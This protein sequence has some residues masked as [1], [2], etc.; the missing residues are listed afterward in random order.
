M[1]TLDPSTFFDN[2][3]RSEDG[4]WRAANEE[5]ISY[6]AGGHAS[7]FAVEDNS[8]WFQHRN[9]CIVEVVR[10]FAGD[11][12]PF[13]D[14]GG[15]NGVV[16]HALQCDGFETVLV[17]PGAEGAANARKRGVDHII[18]A[19][20]ESAGALPNRLPMVGLF[21]VIEHIEDSVAFLHRLRGYLHDDGV[22]FGTV[23]AYQWL[24]SDEDVHAGHFRRYTKESLAQELNGAG[25]RIEYVTYFFRPLIAPIWALRTLPSKWSPEPRAR[26]PEDAERDHASESG[27]LSGLLG[28]MLAGEVG[29]IR[30]GASLSFGASCL[31]AARVRD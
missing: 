28:R 26:A 16:A 27:R 21:D 14:V 22:L 12:R 30:R 3:T 2:L 5:R 31:F 19:T 1:S 20:L 8:F 23:P 25:L 7:C 9:R 18:Q 29:T 6:P 17:E 10:R 11:R 24:W 13:V 4:I 15:G